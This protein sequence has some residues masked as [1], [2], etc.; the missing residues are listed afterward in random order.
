MEYLANAKNQSNPP[1]VEKTGYSG[2]VQR[3]GA[4][5]KKLWMLRGFAGDLKI[6]RQPSHQVA[7]C[8][9]SN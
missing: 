2:D 6:P 4:S 7:E 9:K 1:G 5:A 8:K 3:E